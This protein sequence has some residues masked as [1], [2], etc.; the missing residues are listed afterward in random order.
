[1]ALFTEIEKTKILKLYGEF[2]SIFILA[3]ITL[4]NLYL[5]GETPKT[6]NLFIKNCVFIL[7]YLNFSHL[8]TTL[9]LMKYTYLD[10]FPLLKTV[11]ELIDFDAF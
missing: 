6:W 9:H 10:F 3:T 8:Q 7:T 11:F 2:V 4:K 1:M 5:L